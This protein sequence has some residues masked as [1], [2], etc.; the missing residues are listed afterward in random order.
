[1][2]FIAGLVLSFNTFIRLPS[3]LGLL[4]ILAIPFNASLKGISLKIYLKQ[5]LIFII[6]ALVAF[7]AVYFTMKALGHDAIYIESLR[8][9]KT[10][11]E[12][13]HG[14]YSVKE[15]L[16]I[17]TLKGYLHLF[18]DAM[19]MFLLA[20]L[21]ISLYM[22]SLYRAHLYVKLS[23]LVSFLALLYLSYSLIGMPISGRIT[24]LIATICY[25]TLIIHIFNRKTIDK[26][27]GLISFLTLLLLIIAPLGSGAGQVNILYAIPLAF[28]IAASY[29]HSIKKINFS[30]GALRNRISEQ[31]SFITEDETLSKVKS[32]L[33]FTFILY[34]LTNALAFSY[35]DIYNRFLLTHKI[36]HKYLK[37]IYTT[38]EKA[39]PLNELLVTLPK[40]VGK[41]DTLLVTWVNPMIYYLSE[42]VPYFPH[43]WTEVYTRNQLIR[44]FQDNEKLKLP[45]IVRY[46][47]LK[48][49][50]YDDI[51]NNFLKRNMYERKWNNDTYE[52]YIPNPSS[53]PPLL[54]FQQIKIFHHII[55]LTTQS[56]FV[57]IKDPQKSITVLRL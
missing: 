32:F 10:T 1:M 12:D 39:E 31:A 43:P 26:N 27:L 29:F 8:F 30:L 47:Y 48:E 54:S 33:L 50:E 21:V 15:D 11:T 57:I 3:V 42:S 37:G 41:D 18:T 40:Y 20:I 14:P 44:L 49:H 2:I 55:N 25:A 36:N 5:C 53:Y 35:G 4:F 16:L 24:S 19:T 17:G 34:A 51:L 9:L 52:I 56:K 23:L 38:K 7:T 22:K 46:N 28:P 45:V 6:G 13:T